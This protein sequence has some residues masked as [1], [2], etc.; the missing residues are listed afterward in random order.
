MLSVKYFTNSQGSI[1]VISV[2]EPDSE[3]ED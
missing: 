3:V 2:P 1:C